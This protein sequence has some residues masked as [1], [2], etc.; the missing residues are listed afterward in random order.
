MVSYIFCKCGKVIDEYETKCYWCG[1]MI[2]DLID[3]NNS[4]LTIKQLTK[5]IETL[6]NDQE[7][8]KSKI[9]LMAIEHEQKIQVAITNQTKILHQA[10]ELEQRWREEAVEKLN[11]MKN[12]LSKSE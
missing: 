10:I 11:Q 7:E 5:D 8:L 3:Y 6:R 2:E 1:R 4:L 9:S 12:R